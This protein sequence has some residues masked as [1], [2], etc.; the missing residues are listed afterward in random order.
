MNVKYKSD[1]RFCVDDDCVAVVEDK[2][3]YQLFT[4][5]NILLC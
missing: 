1:H 4:A 2:T 3:C 5:T